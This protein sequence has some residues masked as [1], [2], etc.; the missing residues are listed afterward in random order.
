ML[1]MLG[2]TAL[3]FIGQAGLGHSFAESQSD[4]QEGMKQLL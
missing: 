4:A 2:T 3:E 1:K